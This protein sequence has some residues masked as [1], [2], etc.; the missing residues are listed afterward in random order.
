MSRLV[1]AAAGFF[2][3]YPNWGRVM[4]HLVLR[5]VREG[6]RGGV[7]CSGRWKGG[8]GRVGLSLNVADNHRIS[9][10]NFVAAHVTRAGRVLGTKASCGATITTRSEKR[11]FRV[12]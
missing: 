12:T 8:G 6:G 3:L 9:R 10:A 5:K 4:P 11:K 1:T 2:E 7:G